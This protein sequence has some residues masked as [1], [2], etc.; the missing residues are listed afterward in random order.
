MLGQAI[1]PI[2]GGVLTQYLG[3]RS[4]FMFLF[5]LGAIAV[6]TLTV[7]L[8]ET[9]RQIAGNGTIRL[10]G[11]YRPL[12]LKFARLGETSEGLE[13]ERPRPKMAWKTI[14]DPARMLAEKDIFVILFFGS[15]VYAVWSMVTASTTNLFQHIY[16]LDDLTVGLAFLPNGESRYA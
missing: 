11:I 16:H 7:F 10:H 1:G 6:A 5:I 12:S 3:F 15:I 2:I 9:L 13:S 8:P 4:I 14:F